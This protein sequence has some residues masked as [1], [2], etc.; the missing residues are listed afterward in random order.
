MDL[1]ELTRRFLHSLMR[2]PAVL[3]VGWQFLHEDVRNL[4]LNSKGAHFYHVP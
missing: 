2:D 1:T 3:K 4:K